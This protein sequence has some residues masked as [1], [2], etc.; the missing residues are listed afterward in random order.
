MAE[1]ALWAL[2][3][4]LFSKLNGANSL[5]ADRV[6]PDVAPAWADVGQGYV[7]FFWTGGG[8]DN[9]VVEEDARITLTIKVVS[10]S[11]EDAAKMAAALSSLLNDKGTQETSAPALAS[12]GGWEFTA[13]TKGR[14]VHLVERFSE[15]VNIYHEGN[16][17]E[18]IMGLA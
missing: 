15:A 5:W 1:H 10:D 3:Q 9:T 4:A 14:A 12:Q 6:F 13:I 7:L 17:Y 11:M 18:F 2:Y 8:E 16:S